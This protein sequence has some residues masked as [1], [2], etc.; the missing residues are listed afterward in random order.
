MVLVMQYVNKCL[1]LNE[2]VSNYKCG[3]EL[4]GEKWKA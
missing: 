1:L 3:F 2:A 4:N